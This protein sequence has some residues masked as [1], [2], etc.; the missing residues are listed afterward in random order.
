MGSLFGVSQ[1]DIIATATAQVSPANAMK[2]V[3]PFTIPDRWAEN[4]SINNWN[5]DSTFDP[6]ADTYVGPNDPANYTGYDA[7]RD[8]GMEIT[9]KANNETKITASFYN[10]WDLPG[11]VGAS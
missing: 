1:V 11:S 4:G 5:P 10:P 2:C 9:L 7:K 8:V 6:P 3:K